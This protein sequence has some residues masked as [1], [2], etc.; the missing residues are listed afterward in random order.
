MTQD[1]DLRALARIAAD[2]SPAVVRWVNALIRAGEITLTVKDSDR[3]HDLPAQVLSRAYAA[4]VTPKDQP[5]GC[6]WIDGAEG[7]CITF[8]AIIWTISGSR[9][10]VREFYVCDRHATAAEG[11]LHTALREQGQ[12]HGSGAYSILKRLVGTPPA[13]EPTTPRRRRRRAEHGDD[14]G[15]GA[16]G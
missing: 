11:C 9:L 16:A 1:E 7:W 3:V 6:Q 15:T 12:R 13:T 5:P 10:P 8:A 4:G 14:Y 2:E